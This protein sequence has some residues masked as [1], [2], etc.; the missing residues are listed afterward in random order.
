MFT[1]QE[2]KAAPIFFVLNNLKD[3]EPECN[4]GGEQGGEQHT[5]SGDTDVRDDHYFSA[6]SVVGAIN[7]L[8]EASTTPPSTKDEQPSV[9]AP[10][11]ALAYDKTGSRKSWLRSGLTDNGVFTSMPR[12]H[13]DG[14]HLLDKVKQLKGVH[15]DASWWLGKLK[16]TLFSCADSYVTRRDV[17]VYRRGGPPSNYEDKWFPSAISYGIKPEDFEAVT[18]LGMAVEIVEFTPNTSSPSPDIN[19]VVC[20]LETLLVAASVGAAP[21]V[22]AAFLVYGNSG[23]L[24]G[25]VVVSSV[26]TFTLGDMLAAY[27][28]LSPAD[29][30]SLAI[31]QLHGASRAVVD[32]LENLALAKIVKLNL[33]ADSIVFVPEMEASNENWILCGNGFKIGTTDLIPGVPYVTDFDPRLTRRI[34]DVRYDKHTAL[35]IMTSVLLQ[36]LRAEFGMMATEVVLNAFLGRSVDGVDDTGLAS[37]LVASWDA[38]PAMEHFTNEDDAFFQLMKKELIGTHHFPQRDALPS[39]LY[40]ETLEDF[41][42]ISKSETIGAGL[43]LVHASDERFIFQRLVVQITSSSYVL[44]DAEEE[45]AALDSALHG[46]ARLSS[47]IS[48]RKKRRVERRALVGIH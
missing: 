26:H 24:R 42:R 17:K 33:S 41:I 2:S 8:G 31:Q 16:N 45:R 34:T 40:E 13:E 48:M 3:T 29:N 28:K 35:V 30:R 27:Q 15:G 1:R 10:P 19:E 12:G 44:M 47:V 32:L 21:P 39:S 9:D 23:L 36:A 18:I 46:M 11:T 25:T 7:D 37:Q 20:R 43:T 22:L 14:V 4:P 6:Q 5:P 38:L